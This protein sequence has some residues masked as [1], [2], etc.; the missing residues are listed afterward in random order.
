VNVEVTLEPKLLDRALGPHRERTVLGD[1][2]KLLLLG[3]N[4]EVPQEKLRNV[5]VIT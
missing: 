3:I 4:G 1:R 5:M 2:S